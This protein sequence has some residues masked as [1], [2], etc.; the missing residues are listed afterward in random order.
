M[1]ASFISESSL[2]CDYR[3]DARDNDGYSCNDDSN[4]DDGY[5]N[6]DIGVDFNDNDYLKKTKKNFSSIF[7]AI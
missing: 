3:Y 2:N 4:D 1:T 7:I 6:H 5:V